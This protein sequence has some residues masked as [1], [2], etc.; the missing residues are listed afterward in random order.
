MLHDVTTTLPYL[1]LTMSELEALLCKQ[2]IRHDPQ[3]RLDAVSGRVKPPLELRWIYL[4]L[5]QVM[6]HDSM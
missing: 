4:H 2:S 1:S 3:T 6:M 5:V